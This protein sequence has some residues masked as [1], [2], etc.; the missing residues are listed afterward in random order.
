MNQ[1]DKDTSI[2]SL[3][4]N[5]IKALVTANAQEKKMYSYWKRINKTTNNYLKKNPKPIR[6]RT[7]DLRN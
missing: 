3:P 7:L 2:P 4:L 1:W 6:K 5:I